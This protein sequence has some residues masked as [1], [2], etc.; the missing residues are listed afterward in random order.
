MKLQVVAFGALFLTAPGANIAQDPK[1]QKETVT[2]E[3]YQ[4]LLGETEGLKAKVKSLEEKEAV[5]ATEAEAASADFEKDLRDLRDKLK[6]LI[7]GS[8]NFLLTG[9]AFG[10]FVDREGQNSTFSAGFNPIF[11]WRLSDK[12]FFEGEAELELAEEGETELDLEYA[13]ATYLLNDYM[14]LGAGKFL[15]PFGIFAERLHAAWI[16]KLPDAPLAFGHDGLTP[17][18]EVG[19][20]VRGGFPIHLTKLNYAVFLSNGPRLNSGEEEPEEAGLLHFDNNIDVNNNKSVG[21]RVGFLPIPELEVGYSFI[22]GRVG[23]GELSGVDALLQA[24]DMTYVRDCDI[25]KGFFDVRV[26]WA[27]SRVDKAAYDADGSLG[28]G[29]VS[30]RNNRNG[31]YAQVA[32]RPSKIDQFIVKNLEAVVRFDALYQPR[33]APTSVDESRWTIGLNYW[34]SP[35]VVAKVAY[36]FDDT[37]DPLDEKRDTDAVLAQVA[38]GF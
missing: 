21:S 30:F 10:D 4:K 3:E 31:G 11:L 34:L 6:S 14:T 23:S 1:A 20:Q 35:S 8:T 15:S 28:F 27:W 19:V 29:P 17:T 36:Q 38:M 16:N 24:V 33:G 22:Y 37:D 5:Q 25:L 32:Y 13:Q 18:S 9:Y 7:P 2:R 12:I 26:E